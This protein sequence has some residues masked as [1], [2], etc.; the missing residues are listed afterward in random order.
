MKRTLR[1]TRLVCALSDRKH[2]T[3]PP[4]RLTS[5]SRDNKVGKD[6]HTAHDDYDGQSD[7]DAVKGWI[8]VI[9]DK[10]VLI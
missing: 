1:A 4:A 2:F 6:Q 9:H 10:M 8:C 3:A 5:L 7:N